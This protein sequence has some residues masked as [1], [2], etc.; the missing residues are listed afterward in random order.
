MH[1]CPCKK[2]ENTRKHSSVFTQTST[3]TRVFK[4]N[5]KKVLSTSFFSRQITV[6]EYT[7]LSNKIIITQSKLQKRCNSSQKYSEYFQDIF[8][9][10]TFPLRFCHL[11]YV[12]DLGRTHSR[13]FKQNNEDCFS[14]RSTVSIRYLSTICKKM[15]LNFYR[16]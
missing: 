4:S 12:C 3:K 7:H 1:T 13:R 11:I 6:V 9:Q 14:N 10:L 2:N 8:L 16:I 5:E 15:H